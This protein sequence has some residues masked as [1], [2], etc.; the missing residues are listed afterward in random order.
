MTRRALGVAA[1]VL[2]LVLAA[3]AC[4]RPADT[5][6][7]TI[8]VLSVTTTDRPPADDEAADDGTLRVLGHG[9]FGRTL[10]ELPAVDDVAGWTEGADTCRVVE[11]GFGVPAPDGVPDDLLAA[12]PDFGDGEAYVPARA[13][14]DDA[15]VHLFREG[16]F[17]DGASDESA[18]LTLEP[19]DG[20]VAY[21]GDRSDVEGAPSDL[22]A[23]AGG[24]LWFPAFT[25]GPFPVVV[26]A[27]VAPSSGF[28]RDVR[29]AWTPD[30]GSGADAALLLLTIQA[31][32]SAFDPDLACLVR[33]EAGTFELPEETREE[34]SDDWEG[35]L[36]FVR[37]D[38]VR[39]VEVG[40][41][42]DAG[43]LLLVGGQERRVASEAPDAAD[44]AASGG[45]AKVGGPPGNVR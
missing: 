22:Y 27:E 28:G 41:G 5:D 2:A 23:R 18:Y 43:P 21:V 33:D 37:R 36:T 29:F 39:I 31:T 8:G 1:A 24:A 32:G 20:F 10:A 9:I 11:G 14:E 45:P 38:G 4:S 35:E 30:R 7:G 17:D 44:D 42:F 12:L 13:A 6:W 15:P 25:E 19:E 3:A 34:L 26:A 16:A 40:R